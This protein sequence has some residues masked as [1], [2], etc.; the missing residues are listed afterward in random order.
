MLVDGVK[1][2][3]CAF[4]HTG[5]R[6][7]YIATT[8]ILPRFQGFGLGGLLKAWEI[9]Y[10]RYHG[11]ASH[12]RK[13]NTRMMKLNQKFGFRAVRT[14]RGYYSDPPDSGVLMELALARKR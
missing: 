5:S 11:F 4:H 9:A 3:C 8:G 7:L 1:A 6:T 2:G 10:A 13:K 14:I 12:T